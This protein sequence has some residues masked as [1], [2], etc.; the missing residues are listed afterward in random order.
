MI[1]IPVY[2]FN[3]KKALFKLLPAEFT[4][5]LSLAAV[6]HRAN[7]YREFFTENPTCVSWAVTTSSECRILW[8]SL[9][10]PRCITLYLAT[11]AQ[12]PPFWPLFF[13]GK[14]LQ[15]LNICTAQGKKK[16]KVCRVG[17][18]SVH[19]LFQTTDDLYWK[20]AAQA[21]VDG[22]TSY[23]LPSR[24]LKNIWPI[25]VY[26]RMFSSYPLISF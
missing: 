11:K 22:T 26:V 20:A 23:C 15:V 1:D 21:P 14:H 18:F 9:A 24:K 25:K 6:A 17:D 4:L 3:L 19:T 16:K 13:C 8:T 10:F 2:F 12:L 5:S 7:A